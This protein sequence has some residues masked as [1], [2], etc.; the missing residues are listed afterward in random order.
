VALTHRHTPSAIRFVVEGQVGA[1]T[2]VDGN[3]CTMERGDLI[4]TPNWSWHGHHNDSDEPV[5]WIDGLDVML[6]VALGAAFFEPYPSVEGTP[7][8]SPVDH[9]RRRPAGLAPPGRNVPAL[10]YKW[11]DT[12]PALQAMVQA[13]KSPFDGRCLEYRNPAFGGHTLRTIGCWIQMLE[14][15]EETTVHRH[16]YTHVYHVF[17]GRGTTE[18]EGQVLHWDRGDCL[19][20]PNWSWHRHCNED[21]GK[22]AILFS[23]ND[24]PLL[25][26][27]GFHRE[28]F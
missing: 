3:K 26:S 17:E 4:L 20:V 22:P 12:L 21:A 11:R 7:L 2:V 18:V 13:D 6:T 23:L 19:V 9:A 24:L 10:V 16:T 8:V 27:L 14:P 28:Q 25:E 1:Y 5:I 15:A